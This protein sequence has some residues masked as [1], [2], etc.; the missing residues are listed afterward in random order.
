MPSGSRSTSGTSAPSGVPGAPGT[1]APSVVSIAGVPAGGTYDVA[2]VGLGALGSA[3][4]W[5]LARR[6]YSVLGLERMAF[7]H[8]AGASHGDTR[9]VR[10]AHH[11]PN[12]VSAAIETYEGWAQL[13]ADTGRS[14][15]LRCGGVDLFPPAAAV[16]VEDY[17]NSM[18]A[19]AVPYEVLTASVARARW[20]GLA[21][22]EGTTVV[23]QDRTGVVPAGGTVRILHELARRYG[24]HLHQ[25]QYVVE[26]VDL[27]EGVALRT[28]AGRRFSARRLVVTAD[29]WTNRVLD[30]LD[31]RLPITVTKEQVVQFRVSDCDAGGV[32]GRHAP[33]RFPV[34]TWMD[35]P[36]AYGLP[37]WGDDTVKVVMDGGPELDPEHRTVDID[38]GVLQRARAL[39][40]VLV[41]GAG[42]AQRVST[43]LRTST[44]DGDLVVGAVPG[45]ESVLVGLGGRYGFTY[46]PWFGRVLAD[47][48]T[49]G[50]TSTDLSA[51]SPTRRGLTGAHAPVS[52]LGR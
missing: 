18:A 34:W 42:D 47:L 31:V 35:D 49:T 44:P 33:D 43:C 24:A 12:H 45:H 6:G 3:T 11:T 14:L 9:V 46:A 26:I 13:E 37:T 21:V 16:D 22:P 19:M 29:A 4:A 2:V 32:G 52:W 48:A 10:L 28:G 20:P 17:V 50:T 41:P 15:V 5:Q 25:Y 30:S 27:G 38:E 51:F 23:H 7:L 39:T 8:H 1:S 36:V 40:R